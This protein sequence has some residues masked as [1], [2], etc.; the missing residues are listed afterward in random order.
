MATCQETSS[1]RHESSN[2]LI[3]FGAEPVVMSCLRSCKVMS[4]AIDLPLHA[5]CEPCWAL[6]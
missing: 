3:N 5:H 2:K 4:E 1:C 6:Y